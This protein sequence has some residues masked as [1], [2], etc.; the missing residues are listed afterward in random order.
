M[1]RSAHFSALQWY[2]SLKVH[3]TSLSSALHSP[4]KYIMLHLQCIAL[5]MKYNDFAAYT[6]CASLEVPYAYIEA[7]C[8]PYEVYWLHCIHFIHWNTLP[9][10]HIHCTRAI[11]QIHW[12]VLQVHCNAKYCTANALQVRCISIWDHTDKITVYIVEPTDRK[13]RFPSIYSSQR[14][15]VWDICHNVAYGPKQYRVTLT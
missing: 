13:R 14:T 4:L 5:H 12:N 7:Y 3:C 6:P 10:L 8:T 9:A 11:M 2:A 1:H 15:K